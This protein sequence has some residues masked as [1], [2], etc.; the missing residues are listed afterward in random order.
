MIRL[1]RKN[2]KQLENMAGSLVT[3]T[4]TVALLLAIVNNVHSFDDNG[5]FGDD[6]GSGSGGKLFSFLIS[7][8]SKMFF[9][10]HKAIII[11]SGSD[12]FCIF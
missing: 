11:E 1:E 9:L 6:F 10:S 8:K 2:H 12:Q 5:D 4:T 3:L 7:Q